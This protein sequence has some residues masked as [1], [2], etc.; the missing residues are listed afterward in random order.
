M[1]QFAPF[2]ARLEDIYAHASHASF[3]QCYRT[4]VLGAKLVGFA[5]PS[6]RHAKRV[7]DG[8]LEDWASKPFSLIV[9]GFSPQVAPEDASFLTD[10]AHAP[11]WSNGRRPAWWGDLEI[12]EF[13]TRQHRQSG[14]VETQ[15]LGRTRFGDRCPAKSSIHRYW[16]RL[17]QIH[18]AVQRGASHSPS[19]SKAARNL[20][21]MADERN[22]LRLQPVMRPDHDESEFF[23]LLKA[24]YL[25]LP[26]PPFAESYRRAAEVAHAKGWAIPSKSAARRKIDKRISRLMQDFL[27]GSGLTKHGSKTEAQQ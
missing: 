22:H 8:E 27:R 2:I 24:D 25:R 12:R 20:L 13:L 5:V 23:A 21:K 4:A 16:Q 7:L 19:K 3:T 15:N 26:A 14:L 17:D 1:S 18:Q 9:E 10:L 11:I 6:E